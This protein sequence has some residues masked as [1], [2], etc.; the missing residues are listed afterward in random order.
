MSTQ[1]ITEAVM[2]MPEKE[3]LELA[4]RIIAGIAVERESNSALAQAIAGIE[5]IVPEKLAD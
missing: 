5:D 1:E 4:R 2:A 3:R